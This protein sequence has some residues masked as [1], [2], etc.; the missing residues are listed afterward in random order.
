MLKTNFPIRL[1]KIGIPAVA[2]IAVVCLV[3]ILL[4]PDNQDNTTPFDP[5]A[6]TLIGRTDEVAVIDKQY[7]EWDDRGGASPL[8]IEIEPGGRLIVSEAKTYHINLLNPGGRLLFK[9]GGK[10]RGPGEFGTINDLYLTESGQLFVVD[11]MLRRLTIMQ[12]LENKIT[13]VTSVLYDNNRNLVLQSIF[14]GNQHKYGIFTKYDQIEAGPNTLYLYRLDEDYQPADKLAELPGNVKIRSES[15]LLIDH[16]FGYI[17]NWDIQDPWFYYT[18]ANRMELHGINL[19]NG[20]QQSIKVL[21]LSQRPMTTPALHYLNERMKPVFNVVPDIKKIVNQSDRLPMLGRVVAD[22]ERVV[23]NTFYAGGPNG[24]ILIG[25]N[26]LTSVR[27]IRTPPHFKG[28]EING[29]RLYG[30]D[31]TGPEQPRILVLNLGL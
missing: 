4:W 14:A 10:G 6:S 21:D 30:I 3:W 15:G 17:S 11:L 8:Q 1:K 12:V 26:K 22:S 7:I 5:F 25:D 23:L 2:A 27:H 16:P 31:Y 18:L 13:Y 19:N 29:N 28:L 24:L 9:A 20:Q